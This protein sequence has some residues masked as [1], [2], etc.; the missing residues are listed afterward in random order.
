MILEIA[1][2][3]NLM[4]LGGIIVVLKK[5]SEE[6]IKGLESLNEILKKIEMKLSKD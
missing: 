6:N 4:L 3:I 5:S 2:I 1:A